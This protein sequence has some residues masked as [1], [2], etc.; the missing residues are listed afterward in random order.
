MSREQAARV[1]EDVEIMRRLLE[2]KIQSQ[3]PAAHSSLL[4]WIGVQQCQNCHAPANSLWL[5]WSNVKPGTHP[6]EILLNPHVPA[7]M[8]NWTAVWNTAVNRNW[9][10]VSHQFSAVPRTEGVYLRNQGVV[11]TVTLALDPGAVRPQPPRAAAKPLTEWERL[12]QQIRGEKPQPAAP[13]AEQKEP[14]LA[15]TLLKVLAENGHN[16]SELTA[17][18]SVT[19]VVT[20]RPPAG[21][22]VS[23]S[24]LD[25]GSGV[26]F[27]DFDNDGVL[28]LLVTTRSA[29]TPGPQ[30]PSTSTTTSSTSGGTTTSTTVD[31][32]SSTRGTASSLRDYMLLGDLL[33]KQGKAQEAVAAY[34]NAGKLLD[35]TSP[36]N[37]PKAEEQLRKLAQA[38]LAAGDVKNA[39]SALDQL[40]RADRGPAAKQ[41]QPP[42][43][44]GGSGA[45]SAE[46][47]KPTPPPAKLIVSATKKVLDQ[48]GSGKMSFEDF[49]KAATVQYLDFAP[50]AQ[51]P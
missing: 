46:A 47:P 32:S 44:K 25:V 48:V 28:D 24:L 20:F 45:K 23:A 29:Q 49:K 1:Y 31:S 13:A 38:Y 11:Y 12:R 43:P 7:N 16:F 10:P 9:L 42:A 18:E 37:G 22:G 40:S 41:S 19:V 30:P 21:P 8:R 33:L 39:R 15:D 36:A 35:A 4:G 5:D 2:H 26:S 51:K 17:N 3:V 6:N 34:V 50:A 14:T 27:L